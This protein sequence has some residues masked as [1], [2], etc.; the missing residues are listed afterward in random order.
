[1][2][3][4]LGHGYLTSPALVIAWAIAGH[5]S[6]DMVNDPLGVDEAGQPLTMRDLMPS[7]EE[8]EIWLER[9]MKPEHYI[10]RRDIIWQGTPHWQQIV[11]PEACIIHG[12]D[13][14]LSTPSG[15]P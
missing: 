1:M 5:I 9:I 6:H 13:L 3:P 7:R 15:V 8:V 14:H 10:K 12:G 4:S 11:A 2:N